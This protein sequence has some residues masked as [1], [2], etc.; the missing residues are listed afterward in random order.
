M[1]LDKGNKAKLRVRNLRIRHAVGNPAS[2]R[3]LLSLQEVSD[4]SDGLMVGEKTNIRVVVSYFS[5]ILILS[6][7]T[8][9]DLQQD[10]EASDSRSLAT[11]L[12]IQVCR[13]RTLC[14]TWCG[15]GMRACVN[16]H[17]Y[18]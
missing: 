3:Q 6:D 11:T 17:A 2:R 14:G 5:A 4:G 18:T 10:V 13:R 15:G 9:G 8:K 12:G 16:T 1:L 7:S